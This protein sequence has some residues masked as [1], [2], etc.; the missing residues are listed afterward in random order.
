MERL[1]V[2]QDTIWNNEEII[3]KNN[4]EIVK[5]NMMWPFPLDDP[6]TLQ[7]IILEKT[8][9]LTADKS[10]EKELL[11]ADKLQE[12]ADKLSEKSKGIL[13]EATY[14]HQEV[15]WKQIN[16][17]SENQKNMQIEL[18]VDQKLRYAKTLINI[19]SEEAEIIEESSYLMWMSMLAELDK[20]VSL[21]TKLQIL[22][23][24]EN[25]VKTSMLSAQVIVKIFPEKEED[26]KE[27]IPTYQESLNRIQNNRKYLIELDK[28]DNMPNQTLEEKQEKYKKLKDLYQIK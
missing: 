26:Y 11:T 18:N 7:E 9:W 5:A 10:Q 13:Q 27:T 6:K 15:V 16:S 19:T 17:N 25:R 24:M 22:D 28:I 3:R 14:L 8:E 12:R 2:P 23:S 21:S 4:N 20:P 1:K